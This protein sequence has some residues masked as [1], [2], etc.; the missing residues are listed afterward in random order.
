MENRQSSLTNK[1]CPRQR[2]IFSNELKK[3]LV[4]EIEHKR[5]KVRDVVFV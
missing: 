2:R 1:Y 4:E 3:K 5:I